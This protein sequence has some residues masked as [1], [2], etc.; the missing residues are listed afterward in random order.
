MAFPGKPFTFSFPVTRPAELKAL[1]HLRIPIFL[2][3]T[4]WETR[5]RAAASH[6]AGYQCTDARIDAYDL[7]PPMR[8]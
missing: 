7:Q 5:N 8:F 1:F 3:I 2:Q 4:D 6:L